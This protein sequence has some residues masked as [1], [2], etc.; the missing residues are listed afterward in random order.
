MSLP[1]GDNIKKLRTE[2]KVTQEQFMGTHVV[3]R[4]LTGQ[5]RLMKNSL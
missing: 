2:Q 4:I 1:L 3:Q 5:N